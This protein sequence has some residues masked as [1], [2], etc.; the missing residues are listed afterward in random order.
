MWLSDHKI[1]LHSHCEIIALTR[2]HEEQKKFC[3]A[4]FTTE[5]VHTKAVS[6]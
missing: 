4:V 2:A 1:A 6:W 5:R 3:L